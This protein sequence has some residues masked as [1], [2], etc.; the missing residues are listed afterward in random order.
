VRLADQRSRAAAFQ[1][2]KDGVGVVLDFLQALISEL[3]APVDGAF[4]EAIPLEEA[5]FVG[6]AASADGATPLLGVAEAGSGA[7]VFSDV[8]CSTAA[9][10]GGA[11]RA[12]PAARSPT[13]RN[14]TGCHLRPSARER[15]TGGTL[16]AFDPSAKPYPARER[17]RTPR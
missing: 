12:T 17:T 5:A 9:F 15:I 11:P 16:V 7:P 10:S 2:A 14:K 13:T 4:E 6:R 8:A 1:V 3:A